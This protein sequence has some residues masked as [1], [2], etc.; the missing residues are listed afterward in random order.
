MGTQILNRMKLKLCMAA[1]TAASFLASCGEPANNEKSNDSMKKDLVLV[2]DTANFSWQTEQFADIKIVRYQIPGWE[3]LTTQQR[4]LVYFLT[5]AGYEGRDIIWDQNYRHNIEIRKTLERIVQEYSGDK[6][7]ENWNNFMVYTKRVWF[8]NG[9]HHHYGMDKLTP[10]FD[11][12]YFEGLLKDIG[13][14]VSDELLEA[15]FNPEKDKKKVSLDPSKDLLLASATNFYDPDITEKEVEA[16]YKEK[17]DPTDNTPVSYGLNSKLVRNEN[18]ELEENVW[19]LNGMY[20]AAIERIIYWLEQAVTVAENEAQANALRLLI[21]YYQTGD[22]KKWDEYNIAWVEATEGDIDY[23]NSFIEVYNDPMGYRGSFESIVE[24]KDFAASERMAVV[25]DNV[26]WFEDESPILDEHKKKE[27]VGVTYKVVAVAGESGD[28]SPSTPIGVN[29]PN[30]NWIRAQH[31]SKS[32]S[33]GN[34]IA[35]YDKASGGGYIDEFALTEDEKA[36]AKEHGALSSKLH[37]ALHEVVGHASGKLNPGVGTPKETLK[38]YASTLEEARADLVALYYIMDTKLIDLG[39]MKSLDVGKAE[40]DGYIRNGLM[41]QLRRLEEG[42]VLEEAHMRNRQLVASWAFEKG[43][44]ENVVEKL[45]KDGKTYFR[46]NDYEKLREIF[47][48]LL[49][50][51]QRIKS[52]GDYDAGRNLVE[53]YG[54][55]VDRELHAEVLKRSESLGIAPYGGFINP[56]LVPITEGDSIV[57]VKV[58]YPADFTE[59]MLHYSKAYGN[60]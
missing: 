30:A 47:G 13:A 18:G 6:T 24:I 34:I 59:Q 7:S 5:Q 46:I 50:E 2:E 31:G 43:Q 12:N 52:E 54:V 37:T 33:L 40:Y 16:F 49:K 17:A 60:L 44:A 23:I 20:S 25:M 58:T 55:Q 45:Q 10:A 32:V 38:N 19:K 48:E 22:L 57:D 53:N 42:K 27:V 29:L 9:I 8:S 4:K 15:I 1:V 11:Q 56:M 26:Q 14:V 35:A 28:A 39:L 21:E 36:R 3:K 51:I 41:V